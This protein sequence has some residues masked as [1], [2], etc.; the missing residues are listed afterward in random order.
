MDRQ[1]LLYTF[2]SG[3][4]KQTVTFQT[5]SLFEERE[6]KPVPLPLLFISI[7]KKEDVIIIGDLV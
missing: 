2:T 6:K 4:Y 7:S 3:F 5:S 1:M